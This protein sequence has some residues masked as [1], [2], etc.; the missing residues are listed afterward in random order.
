MNHEL[1]SK[2]MDKF[3]AETSPEKMIGFFEELGYKFTD[4]CDNLPY[5]E[6]DVYGKIEYVN[7]K[8]LKSHRPLKDLLKGLFRNNSEKNKSPEVLSGSFF[9]KIAS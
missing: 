4:S 9:C 2:K 3:F 1:L 7:P 8:D 6:V 5:R